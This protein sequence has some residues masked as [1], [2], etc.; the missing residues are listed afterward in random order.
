MMYRTN[1]LMFSLLALVLGLF[2]IT[3]GAVLFLTPRF[4][5]K[6]FPLVTTATDSSVLSGNSVNVGTR[7]SVSYSNATFT[8]SDTRP[9]TR[10]GSD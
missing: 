7:L 6:C 3:A 2:L 8:E 1:Q 9:L 10:D 5:S 4:P